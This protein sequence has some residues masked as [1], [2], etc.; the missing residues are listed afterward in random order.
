MD[1]V[2]FTSSSTPVLGGEGSAEQAMRIFG[3]PVHACPHHEGILPRLDIASLSSEYFD[4]YGK[5]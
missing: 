4:T 2:L 3:R 1:S 5:G